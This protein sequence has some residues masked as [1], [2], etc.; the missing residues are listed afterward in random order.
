MRKPLVLRSS[1]KSVFSGI[2]TCC[3]DPFDVG[4]SGDEADDMLPLSS[5]RKRVEAK[6]THRLPLR[7]ADRRQLS[8]GFARNRI[9]KACARRP[10][11]RK[12]VAGGSAA[13][14]RGFGSEPS[15]WDMLFRKIHGGMEFLRPISAYIWRVSMMSA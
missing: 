6:M 3:G 2:G 15:R 12:T 11:I 9:D 1:F 5:F 4:S 8:H 10:G 13:R 7:C 14:S